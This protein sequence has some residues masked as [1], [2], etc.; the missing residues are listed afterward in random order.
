MARSRVRPR[1]FSRYGC[2]LHIGPPVS[3][4]LPAMAL[5]QFK[6]LT[7]DALDV[8]TVGSFWA[9][10]LGQEFTSDAGGGMLQPGLDQPTSRTV[11]INQ[12][13]EPKTDKNRVHLD[14][15]V[16]GGRPESLG[17][18]VVR[19]PD[20]EI[21]WTVGAD[22]EGNEVCVFDLD[23]EKSDEQPGLLALVVDSVDPIAQAH[24]WAHLLDGEVGHNDE[25]TEAWV[26]NA[27]GF[28]IENWLF[29]AVPEPKAGKNRIH[30]DVELAGPDAA[31]LIGA[32]AKLVREPDDEISWWELT[33]P[34]GNEFQA[35]PRADAREQASYGVA[36]VLPPTIDG[37]PP[38]IPLE[39]GA[40]PEEQ[41]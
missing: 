36:F 8:D 6:D 38:D 13:D 30:W 4:R 12:V 14:V 41:V 40:W 18:T 28:P 5:A 27:V 7:I 32:G 35:Y 20:D 15:R 11:W 1:G 22:P 26:L 17:A 3:G 25:G 21:S 16:A 31:G 29:V 37:T 34:E 23:P 2:W 33:D 24:W 9:K 19:E 10:A 39:E